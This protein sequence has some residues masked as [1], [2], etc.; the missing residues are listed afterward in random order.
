MNSKEFAAKRAQEIASSGIRKFFDIAATMDDVISL[1]IG[2]PD[3]DTPE[4]I[5]QAGIEALRKGATHYTSN[6]GIL[7]LR[8]AIAAH[9]AKR[10]QQA[11]DPQSEILVT[12]GVS[13]ALY[14]AMAGILDP[15]DEIIFPEPSFV[16][17]QPTA[18][19]VG[20]KPVVIPT[21][22]QNGFQVSAKD[23]ESTITERTKALFIASPN[24]P[25][26]TVIHRECLEEIAAVVKKHNLI[27]ISDEIYDRLVYGVEHICFSSLPGMHERTILLQG[28]SKAYAMTGWRIGYIAGPSGLIDEMRKI[29]QYL[30]MSAPTVAQWAA[31]KALEVGEPYIQEMHAEYDRRRQ[32]IVKGL[33]E[34]GL[35]CVK[36]EGAFYAFPYVAGTGMDDNTFAELLLKEERVAAIPGRGF[37]QSGIGHVRM[38]YATAYD[39]IEIALERIARF[40]QRHRTQ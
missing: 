32:L 15:G 34:I 36:P 39:K 33:N 20:G 28:F 1:G 6:S 40:V 19:M 25:T 26:G 2:E 14:L 16:S 8:E 13:E 9:I 7:E 35:P 37:G 29:H 23:I 24:N 4:P 11:Y 3:F 38:S 30:I 12:V 21:S 22:A 31:L 5:I 27:V 10:Y 18:I 17:Y